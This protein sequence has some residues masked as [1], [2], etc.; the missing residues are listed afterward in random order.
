MVAR[1]AFPWR[2][3]VTRLTNPCRST[4][5]CSVAAPRIEQDACRTRQRA[6]TRAEQSQQSHTWCGIGRIG[7]RPCR[8]VPRPRTHRPSTRYGNHLPAFRRPKLFFAPAGWRP[9]GKTKVRIPFVPGPSPGRAPSLDAKRRSRS[10][11]AA[12]GASNSRPRG[13]QRDRITSCCSFAVNPAARFSS[14]SP[15]AR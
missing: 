7:A 14:S 6:S 8:N 10:I 2:P 9:C 5:C 15:C 4:L 13:A 1:P 12:P 11:S 3:A